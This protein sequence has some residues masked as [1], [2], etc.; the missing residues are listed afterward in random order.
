MQENDYKV[1]SK[2]GEEY[3]LEALTCAECGGALVFPSQ[4]EPPPLEE[5]EADVLVRQS[6]VNYLRELAGLLQKN[7]IRSAIRFH[8]CPP[9]T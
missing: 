4:Y 5:D 1:C 3:A 8:G 6:Q 9:G 7:R 2:C